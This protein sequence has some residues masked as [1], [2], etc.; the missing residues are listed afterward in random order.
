M[1]M[2]ISGRLSGDTMIPM[3]LMLNRFS[4][5]TMLRRIEGM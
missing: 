2:G 4:S 5:I 3:S 1:A